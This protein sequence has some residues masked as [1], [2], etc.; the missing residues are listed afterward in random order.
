MGKLYCLMGKSSS[1]KDTIYKMLMADKD[2]GLKKVVPYT[3]RPIRAGEEEGQEYHFTDKAGLDDLTAKGKVVET[4]CYK[5]VHGDWYY[6]TVDDGNIDLDNNDYR[7]KLDK[8]VNINDITISLVDKIDSNGNDVCLLN[9]NNIKLPLYLRNKK[10]GD[11]I[12]LF[13]LQ[14][15]KKVKDIFIEKRIPNSI[16]NS[17]PLLVDSLDNILWIPFLKK[18][19]YN[20]KKDEFYDIIL[21]SHQKEEK[22]EKKQ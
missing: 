18:S 6:F 13:G 20:S 19:K 2:L 16:R 4:R 11:Y 21:T 12:E 15:K 5:T 22:D 17:Y 10:D 9:S 7:I 1:G 8:S 14:G 3:T